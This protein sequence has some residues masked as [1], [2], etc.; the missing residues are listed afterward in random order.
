MI[1]TRQ[2]QQGLRDRI[3]RI[4]RD[5]I[6]Y[7]HTVQQ[8]RSQAQRLARIDTDASQH[9]GGAYLTRIEYIDLV[10]SSESDPDSE[11]DAE[12]EDQQFESTGEN[13]CLTCHE[14]FHTKEDL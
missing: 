13:T 6:A 8:L 12:S 10:T 14:S 9:G 2:Q 3:R 1:R 5:I 11:S 7:Q 4:L